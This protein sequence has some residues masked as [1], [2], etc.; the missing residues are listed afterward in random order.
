[1]K[2]S[3]RAGYGKSP[4]FIPIFNKDRQSYAQDLEIIQFIEDKLPSR[5]AAWL[6]IDRFFKYVYPFFPYTNESGFLSKITPIIGARDDQTTK[7]K[8]KVESRIDLIPVALFLLVIHLGSITLY[9][10]AENPVPEV[11]TDPDVRYLIENPINNSMIMLARLAT[12]PFMSHYGTA[13]KMFQI[14]LFLK[15]ADQYS[16]GQAEQLES[17]GSYA[18]VFQTM[19]KLALNRDPTRYVDLKEKS[20]VINLLRKTWHGVRCDD[21]F[22]GF[23]GDDF[24]CKLV[25]SNTQLPCFIGES[26]SGVADLEIEKTTISCLLQ[27]TKFHDLYRDLASVAMNLRGNPYVKDLLEFSTKLEDLVKQELGD[28]DQL[29]TLTTPQ[30]TFPQRIKKATKNAS[31]P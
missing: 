24:F 30:E 21:Y 13:Y 4:A 3:D 26:A 12:R 20:K 6:L 5:K 9:D 2:K 8:L 19:V 28:I 25:P 18:I 17:Q 16:P 7:L 27:R 10:C 1:M 14:Y 15:I 31:Q 22:P 11:D 29:L 23:T